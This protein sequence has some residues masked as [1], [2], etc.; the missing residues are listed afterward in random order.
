MLRTGRLLLSPL[1]PDDRDELRGLW[2]RAEVRAFL[3]DGETLSDE[4]IVELITNSEKDFAT[5]N[6]GFW[7]V[8]EIGGDGSLIGTAG[9]RRLDDGPDVEVVY[10]LDPAWWGRGLASEAAAAVVDYA[11]EVLGVD[12]VLAEIDEG[13][14]ASIAVV[15]RLG[16]RPFETVPGVLGPMIHFA[17]A[18]PGQV[19]ETE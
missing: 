17:L 2:R 11:F 15:E 4:R 5:E 19:A 14:T 9:L 7:A 13:N 10:N 8:R 6:F 16:M 12:R 1:H 18:N 3:F